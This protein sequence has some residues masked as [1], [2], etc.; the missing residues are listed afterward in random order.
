MILIVAVMFAISVAVIAFAF[1]SE[2][3]D[4]REVAQLERMF[5]CDSYTDDGTVE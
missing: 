5:D 4:D 1:W 2:F 3:E